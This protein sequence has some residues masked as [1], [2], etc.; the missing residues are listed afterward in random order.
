QNGFMCMMFYKR[1]SHVIELQTGTPTRRLEEACTGL[2]FDR[3]TASYITLVTSNP[4]QRKCP[5]FGRYSVSGVTKR[6][7]RRARSHEIQSHPIDMIGT[8]SHSYAN[9]NYRRSAGSRKLQSFGDDED[10]C[11]L[12]LKTLVVGC[13]ASDTMEFRSD[14]DNSPEKPRVTS[15]YQCHGGWVENGTHFLITTP[16]SR[17]S[18]GARRYCFAYEAASGGSTGGAQGGPGGAPGGS[19]GITGGSVIRFSTSSNTCTRDSSAATDSNVLAF[20][21]TNQGQ[22]TE[23]SSSTRLHTTAWLHLIALL[24]LITHFANNLRLH[25]QL[26]PLIPPTLIPVR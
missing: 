18:R 8:L 26:P 12:D 22:C 3:T 21:I 7:Q 24:Q 17:S 10:G 25:H 16:L 4:E 6:D 2:Y 15:V 1:D 5:H 9:Q 23:T 13:S 11:S 14:C 20:N 19:G